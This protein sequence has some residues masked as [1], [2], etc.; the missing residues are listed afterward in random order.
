MIRYG[1]FIVAI[2]LMIGCS[3]GPRPPVVAREAGRV[4][5]KRSISS[6]SET[7]WTIDREPKRDD[8]GSL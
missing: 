4:D 8:E 7:E 1:P 2:L 5:G 6:M 3:S